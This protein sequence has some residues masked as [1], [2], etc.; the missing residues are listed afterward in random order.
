MDIGKWIADAR[1][2]G[3]LT[4]LKLADEMSV[5]KGNVSGW[6]NNRHAP[7]YQQMLRISQLTGFA[8][9]GL[10]P[11]PVPI[12]PTI[13]EPS[14]AHY[15]SRGDTLER[16][17]QILASVPVMHRIAVADT[18][19]GWAREGGADHWRQMLLALLD[20]PGKQ[21]RTG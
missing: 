12:S 6:E 13:A 2:H 3:Q 4:Q 21:S 5:T 10:T 19:G 18:L 16:M 17:G 9:P 8:L 11:A 14:P 15:P 20:A 1:A 7:S